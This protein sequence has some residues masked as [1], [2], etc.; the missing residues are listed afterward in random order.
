MS[1][2]EDSSALE[3]FLENGDY[4]GAHAF[5]DQWVTLIGTSL[6]GLDPFAKS[7][8]SF[9]P[10]PLP[11]SKHQH[12][13]LGIFSLS[14]AFRE[15]AGL[16]SDPDYLYLSVINRRD[17]RRV[18]PE[19]W[20][21]LDG[22]TGPRILLERGTGSAFNLKGLRFTTTPLSL[23]RYLERQSIVVSLRVPTRRPLKLVPARLAFWV[24]NE[25][26]LPR[27][28]PFTNKGSPID[29]WNGW[30]SK[31]PRAFVLTHPSVL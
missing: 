6:E 19:D 26:K 8:G 20:S 3:G 10:A 30:P 27:L 5:L 15:D 29:F 11:L 17:G 13:T 28:D 31:R 18:T 2:W 1:E 14:E 7:F 23:S 4:L 25:I 22:E 12:P 24:L 16:S 21:K 9:A